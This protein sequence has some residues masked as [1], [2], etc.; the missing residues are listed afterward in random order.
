MKKV[1]VPVKLREPSQEDKN[2]I[3]S[4]W[5]KSFRNSDFPRRMCNAVYYK[6]HQI[7]IKNLLDDCLI[8][9]ACDPEDEQHI[10]GYAVYERLPAGALVLHYLYT[11]FHCRKLGVARFMVESIYSG[12][13][14]ILFTH[15]T[16]Y[17]TMLM[18]KKDAVYDPYRL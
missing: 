11:K 7:V 6:N 1:K 9:V 4:S 5:L 18:T 2:F 3:L 10:F 16:K 17:S 14:P 12:D 8:T 15:Y 13:L